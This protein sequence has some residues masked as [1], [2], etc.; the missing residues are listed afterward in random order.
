[1]RCEKRAMIGYHQG[2][3]SS[4]PLCA[5]LAVAHSAAVSLL[6]VHGNFKQPGSGPSKN[7]MLRPKMPGTT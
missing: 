2:R 3:I 5:M 7:Q 6:D 4:S 1:M